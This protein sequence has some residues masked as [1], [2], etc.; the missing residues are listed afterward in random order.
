MSILFLQCNLE[1]EVKTTLQE[2]SQEEDDEEKQK[3][4]EQTPEEESP[5]QTPKEQEQ[6]EDTATI[7]WTGS[8]DFNDPSWSV[9]IQISAD[10]FT[11][12]TEGST[13][14]VEWYAS[15]S[16]TDYKKLKFNSMGSAWTELTGGSFSGGH[17][18][19]DAGV[20]PDSSPVSYTLTSAN[21]TALKSNGF[22]LLG[23]GVVVTKITLISGGSSSSGGDSSSESTDTPPNVTPKATPTSVTGTPFA[24]HGKLHISGAYLYDE[25]NKKYM[26]YGMSTHGITFGDDFSRYVNKE[27]FKTLVDDWN[28]NCL[29]IVLYPRDYNGYCSGGDKAKLK[30]IVKNGIDYATEC[31]MYVLVD[32]HVH[33]Y[34]PQETKAEAKAFLSEIAAEYA[35]YDNVLY[36]IC[37]EPTGSPWAS[38]IKP[39][40]EEVIPEIRKYANDAVI[41]VGTNNWSQDVEEALASPLDTA[42]YGN[43]MYTFHFYADT[44]KS[45]FRTRVENAI[46][47]G[48][49]IFITEFGTCDAS[50]NGGFNESESKKWFDLCK[51]YSIS[52]LNWSLC[53]KGETASAIQSNCSKTSGWSESELTESGKLVRSHFISDC[54]R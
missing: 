52:H 5:S 12:C 30:Q 10:N 17:T 2:Q 1:T 48:L 38:S 32:W 42:T 22:A 46:K 34:N 35:N 49:P 51:T 20:V 9:N 39:Y 15:S 44:H 6:K 50:G 47:G 26:L 16:A 23:Y 24:N 43:V 31:G 19:S 18:D 3:Q 36:E 45:E 11:S 53:N 29:R 25:H 41:V 28:T 14:Q 21:A 7:I 8:Q 27:A 13:I 4:S 37:N 40:A 33:N 54:T